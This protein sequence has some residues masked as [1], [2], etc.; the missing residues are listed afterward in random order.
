MEAQGSA[1]SH[2]FFEGKNSGMYIVFIVRLNN[3][4]LASF[5]DRLVSDNLFA[6]NK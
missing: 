6:I 3:T 5:E 1:T 2:R 4:V